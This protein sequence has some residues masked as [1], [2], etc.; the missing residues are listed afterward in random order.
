MQ[1]PIRP[2]A[3]LRAVAGHGVEPLASQRQAILESARQRGWPAPTVYADD[4]PGP[5]DGYGA[6]LATLSEAIGAGRYDAVLIASPGPVSIRPEYLTS[7]LFRCTRQGVAVE[8]L[9][10]PAAARRPDCA[11]GQTPPFP[12]PRSVSDVLVSAGLEALSGL[13]PD[14]RIWSDDHGWHARRRDSAYEQGYRRGAPAFCVHADSPLDLAAQLRWQQAADAHAP[15]GC[16]AGTEHARV[17]VG[18]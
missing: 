3:Y 10:S 8:F 13:F 17:H 7:F 15:F 16:S 2:A 5:E 11:A 18:T 9:G 12:L 14:W 4:D 6:A 1:N